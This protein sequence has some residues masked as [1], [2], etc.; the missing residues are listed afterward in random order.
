M[1]RWPNTICGKKYHLRLSQSCRSTLSPQWWRMKPTAEKWLKLT[2][3]NSQNSGLLGNSTIVSITARNRRTRT[4]LNYI[5]ANMAAS[6]LLMYACE[7]LPF[8]TTM[9]DRTWSRCLTDRMDCRGHF[10]RALS[11]LPR[12]LNS[13]VDSKPGYRFNKKVQ[14]HSASNPPRNHHAKTI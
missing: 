5:I 11:F 4:N 9:A 1:N 3:K 6:D 10:V 7:P 8:Q 2:L 12:S 13:C 14:T